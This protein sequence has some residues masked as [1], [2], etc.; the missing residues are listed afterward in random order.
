MVVKVACSI[1]TIGFALRHD[2]L[3]APPQAQTPAKARKE[4][5][6]REESGTSGGS[7]AKKQAKAANSSKKAPKASKKKASK[8][9]P[10]KPGQTHRRPPS[11][12]SSQ[13][14]TKNWL[15]RVSTASCAPTNRHAITRETHML[16]HTSMPRTHMM[17]VS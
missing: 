1:L 17:H 6:K 9:S 15:N 11:Q 14:G 8:K 3:C 16:K 4:K 13:A 10:R 2:V 12:D 7:S 5:R